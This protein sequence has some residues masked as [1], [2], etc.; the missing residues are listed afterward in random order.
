MALSRV[1]GYACVDTSFARWKSQ[2]AACV[3]VLTARIQRSI[4]SIPEVSPRFSTL[5]QGQALSP[6]DATVGGE[7]AFHYMRS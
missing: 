6:N 4:T 2:Q 7:G 5:R 1:D 3:S